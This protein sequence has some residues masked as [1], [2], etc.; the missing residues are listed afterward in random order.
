MNRL[1]EKRHRLG[2]RIQTIRQAIRSKNRRPR[3]ILN[4]SNKYLFA[5][6][7]DDE[8]GK[9]VCSASTLEKS[10][11]GPKKNLE[12]AK[13]LGE[14]LAGRAKE[15]GITSVVFDRRGRLYHG[16]MAHFA[17][18]AREGGLEF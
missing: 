17:D 9:V 10:Y 16:R 7:V 13:K 6:I 12:A 11:S 1:Q 5:Q 3:L 14:I 2:K 8:T 15:K 18:A 4:R